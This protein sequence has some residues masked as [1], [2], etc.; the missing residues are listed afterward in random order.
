M[1]SELI[2]LFKSPEPETSNRISEEDEKLALAALMVRAARIDGEYLPHEQHVI[3]LV[4]QELGP[5]SQGSGR[6]GSTG[7]RYGQVHARYQADGAVR[8]QEGYC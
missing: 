7:A 8:G 6:T 5:D 1:I 3:D 4:L 2:A